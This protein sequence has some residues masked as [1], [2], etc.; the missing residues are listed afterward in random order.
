MPGGNTCK[1]CIISLLITFLFLNV[2][3]Q[4]DF[5]KPIDIFTTPDKFPLPMSPPIPV[6]IKNIFNFTIPNIDKCAESSTSSPFREVFFVAENVTYLE[7]GEKALKEVV[8]HFFLKNIGTLVIKEKAFWGCFGSIFMSDI[9]N[10]SGVH[11]NAFT[12]S[13]LRVYSNGRATHNTRPPLTPL[14]RIKLFYSLSNRLEMIGISLS[15]KFCMI[16]TTF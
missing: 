13:D 8:V 16:S 5:T 6:T 1:F 4:K 14:Q 11:S 10:G 7:I 3:D 12:S 9:A 15:E 2:K